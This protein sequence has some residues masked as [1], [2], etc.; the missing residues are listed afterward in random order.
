MDRLATRDSATLAYYLGSKRR[1]ARE[2]ASCVRE[3]NEG[4][5]VIDLFSGMGSA[6][7]SLSI[8]QNVTSIDVQEYSRVVCAA[9]V[10]DYSHDPSL[11]K[12]FFDL[13]D[14]RLE[15]LAEIYRPLIEYEDAAIES[16]LEGDGVALSGIIEHG[17]M[18]PE[19]R[20]AVP[21]ELSKAMSKV[22]AACEDT[23]L[24]DTIARYFGGTYFSYWQAV[25]L[26]AARSCILELPDNER[27]RFLASI[28]CA[29]SRC[30]STVGGQFAQPLRTVGS[31]GRIKMQTLAKAVKQRQ[32]NLGDCIRKTLKEI[33]SLRKP[34][35]GNLVIKDECCHYLAT[36]GE[37]VGAVY[38][39]PPYSRYHYSRYYHVLE[40][41]AIGDEPKVTLN[42]A[43]KEPS[44]GV[45]REGRYQSPFS[46]RGGAH[47]SFERLLTMCAAA[48]P[49]LVLSYSPYPSNKPS[50]PRMVTI[51]E[52]VGIANRFFKSVEIRNVEGVV[53]SKLAAADEILDAAKNA[54]VLIVCKR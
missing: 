14:R 11:D 40:T 27:D 9:L 36:L 47:E 38:A 22:D 34:R 46:T 8:D 45:Y 6:S 19:Y 20:K 16:Y 5:R 41:I 49:A 52:L 3:V 18:L 35:K 15:N 2:L 48:A 54:E 28:V 24:P 29:A 23:S 53:H 50:T 39:D 51:A 7:L 43:T 1:M 26:A 25:A 10:A 17:C 37:Q 44:R 42:P 33:D 30:G 31:N 4:G 32:R 21:P 13:F 12:L